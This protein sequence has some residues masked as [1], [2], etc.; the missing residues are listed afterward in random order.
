MRRESVSRENVMALQRARLI[1]AAIEVVDEV[2]Y[3][4]LTVGKIVAR[5]RVSRKTF[6]DAFED[7]EDCFCAAFDS[8]IDLARSRI[9]QAIP[10]RGDWRERLRAAVRELLRLMD[11][12]PGLARLCVVDALGAS[13]AALR[14][15]ARVLAEL[16][17]FLETGFSSDGGE[18]TEEEPLY[19]CALIGGVC[20]VVHERILT[21]TERPLEEL[22]GP[23]MYL[24]TSVY[25][26]RD[27]ASKELELAKRMVP[28]RVVRAPRRSEDELN[29]LKIRLTYRTVRVLGVISAAPAASNREIAAEAGIVDQGQMSKLLHRLSGL[30]LVENR[31]NGQVRGG[32]N[33]WYLTR[34]GANVLRTVHPAHGFS[35]NG[36]A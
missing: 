30:G 25:V 10:K 31:G 3:Q 4:Q 15:R 11:A 20:S 13:E 14:R 12:E 18:E 24:I 9:E 7:R 1:A 23:A 16:A 17:G 36:R 5:S 22:V 34:L 29:G 19:A 8:V 6:Y 26:G 28:R 33:A 21:E 2:G 32:A 27:E 35:G